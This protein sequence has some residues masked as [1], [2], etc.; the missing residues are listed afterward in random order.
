MQGRCCCGS[1]TAVSFG[2]PVRVWGCPWCCDTD[3][4]LRNSDWGQDTREGASSDCLISDLHLGYV[5]GGHHLEKVIDAVNSTKP[6]LVCIAGDI[7]DGDATAL[8][9][10]G[11]A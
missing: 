2:G 3:K 6:D 1:H 11:D 8:A 9:D 5:I 7:F 4:T 10:A